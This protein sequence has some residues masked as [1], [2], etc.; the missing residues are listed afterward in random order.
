MISPPLLDIRSTRGIPVLMFRFGMRDAG[1]FG[2]FSAAPTVN[3]DG[4]VNDFDFTRFLREGRI[5]PVVL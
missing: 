3:L 4:V 2:Y 5:Y 1:A